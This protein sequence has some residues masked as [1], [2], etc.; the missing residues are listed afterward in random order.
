[1]ALIVGLVPSIAVN[2][3][4]WLASTAG[5]VPACMPYLDG[6]TSI[7]AI[8][9]Q[10]P[11]SFVFRGTVLP[12]AMLLIVYWKLCAGWLQAIGAARRARANTIFGIGGIGALFLAL[13]VTFLGAEGDFNNLMRR[14]G[15]TVF[16][17]FS[18]LAQLLFA[19]RMLHAAAA[20]AT[21]PAAVRNIGR[22]T[23]GI[24]ALM[25][26]IGLASIPVVNFVAA[27]DRI[28]NIMEWNFTL[29]MFINFTLTWFAWRATG[30]Q[31]RPTVRSLSG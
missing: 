25:L 27:K 13:Y 26:A 22:I 7:S 2:V 11:S 28:Q 4:Y 30:F 18:Y 10:P 8:G 23:L 17:G 24:C 5:T 21:L 9:R 6:C 14:Y 12:I 3:S 19:E 31:V 16:F 29:L 1:M 20:H 15:I